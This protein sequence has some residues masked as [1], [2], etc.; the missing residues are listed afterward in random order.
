MRPILLL[1]LALAS[2]GVCA[3]QIYKWT[4]DKGVIHYS[5]NPPPGVNATKAGIR[6]VTPTAPVNPAVAAKKKE[7]DRVKAQRA[8]ACRAGL[9]Q[10]TSLQSIPQKYETNSKG[11]RVYSSDGSIEAKTK[12]AQIQMR[13][14]CD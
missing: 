4:D 12:Q 7:D 6:A 3:Q 9:A 1:C 10:I 11:E 14:N 13:K 2:L 8:T 5:E